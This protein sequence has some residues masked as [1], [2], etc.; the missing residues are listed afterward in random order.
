MHFILVLKQERKYYA[1]KI[2]YET[3]YNIFNDVTNLILL[4]SEFEWICKKFIKWIKKN[5]SDYLTQN[6]T[7][8]YLI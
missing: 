5:L 6:Y 3:I 4:I 1:S 2:D 8:P 7:R